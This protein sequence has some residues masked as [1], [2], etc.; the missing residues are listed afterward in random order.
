MVSIGHAEC[1]GIWFRAA[2]LVALLVVGCGGNGGVFEPSQTQT[3]VL[4]VGEQARTIDG[5]LGIRFVEVTDDSRCPTDAVCVWAGNGQV[6]IRLEPRNGSP[7]DEELNTNLAVGPREIVFRGYRLEL[8][9][10]SPLPVSTDP[11]P[12]GDYEATLLITREST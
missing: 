6:A 3:V 5:N 10:L 11:I 4:G 9:T 8:V 7:V 1:E 2:L 12:P